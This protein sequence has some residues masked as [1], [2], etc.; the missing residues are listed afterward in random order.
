MVTPFNI[1]KTLRDCDCNPF[2]RRK[3]KLVDQFI[4]RGIYSAF[5]PQ[6]VALTR[7]YVGVKYP[8]MA[9]PWDYNATK[10]PTNLTNA[11]PGG[12]GAWAMLELTNAFNS[13]QPSL[14]RAIISSTHDIRYKNSS[15][16]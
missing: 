7:N 14:D 10:C 15:N 13:K 6:R 9:H 12:R 16:D 2:I 8:G 4:H 3:H 1:K 11:P 5:L